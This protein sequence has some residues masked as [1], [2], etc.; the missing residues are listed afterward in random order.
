M[1]VGKAR[2]RAG[3]KAALQE[4]FRYDRKAVVDQFGIGDACRVKQLG[5]HRNRGEAGQGVD[6]VE[7]HTAIFLREKVTGPD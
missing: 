7:D 3:L 1:G 5:I 4:A 6:L 2:D